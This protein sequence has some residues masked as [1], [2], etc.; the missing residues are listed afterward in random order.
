VKNEIFNIIKDRTYI[1]ITLYQLENRMEEYNLS[2]I[3]QERIKALYSNLLE[4]YSK[5]I[6]FDYS[7]KFFYEDGYGKDYHILNLKEAE[8]KEYNDDF[9]LANLLV[10]YEQKILYQD[11]KR[12]L[13]DYNLDNPLLLFVGHTVSASGTLTNDDKASISDVE[14]VIQFINKF[15]NSRSDIIRSI[16]NI[17]YKRS[18]KDREGQDVFANRF[19]YIK[20]KGLSPVDIYHDLL[21]T[22]FNATSVFSPVL[23]LYEIKNVEGEI[24]LKI[25]GEDYFGLI[26][27]GDISRLSKRM[28]TTGDY[29]I[30]E[31]HF[32]D[33]FFNNINNHNSA[34]NFLIGSRK[35]IEGWNSYRVSSIGLL[36][37]GRSEGSQIIQ[38]FG[39]GVRLRGLNNSLKRSA[40]FKDIEHPEYIE[41]LET[42]NIF[43]IKADYMEKFREYLEKE[44][45]D[46][47]GYEEIILSIKSNDEFLQ[48]DLL[49]IKLME[50]YS[51]QEDKFIPL[52]IDNNIDVTLD[53][54]PK[55]ERLSSSEQNDQE[56][57]ANKQR[58][59]IDDLEEDV[60]DYLNW[61]NLY[62]ELINYK[63][64]QGFNNI[65]IKK[66]I[67]REIISKK[68]Y[69]LYCNDNDITVNLFQDLADIEDI[70]S[71]ILKK[72]VSQ[73]YQER[74]LAYENSYLHFTPLTREDGNFADYAV[75]VEKKNQK[76]IKEIRDLISRKDEIYS[77]QLEEIE[78]IPNVY[79]DRHLFQPLLVQGGKIKST[80]VG[81]NKDEKFFVENLKEFFLNKQDS[82]FLKG[83]EI[84]ILRN[85]SRGKGV[86]FYVGVNFYPDFILW[87]KEENKQFI[88]FID[89]KGI[90]MLHYLQNPKIQLHR[91]LKDIEKELMYTV[92][93]EVILNSFI[94]SNTE[95]KII[96]KQW[97]KDKEE[98][99]ANNVLFA[100]DKDMIAMLFREIRNQEVLQ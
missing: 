98:L 11:K 73:F 43:G 26:N 42:L 85:L 17:I 14:F 76:L 13:E 99:E 71:K 72:Y 52:E 28:E 81:L 83:Q 24:G 96:R 74:K 9:L 44:G 15:L 95:S 18:F 31:D 23:E 50:G 12:I 10:F 40:G 35:F 56:G 4:E 66:D 94:I 90:L 60:L 55:L 92:D 64:Q 48:K 75:R 36:N 1:N 22:V 32:S 63:K 84:F 100:E 41:L 39:R 30:R 82:S 45:I 25:K 53:L 33:S 89:P 20:E 19:I 70:V 65:I 62:L 80:P 79:F 27:I 67:L 97:G 37:I 51:F 87:I 93:Y 5:A 34:I 7:Y 77:E 91:M 88:N 59:Y 8:I 78:S 68:L 2:E 61:N 58:Y 57:V 47:G 29:I 38:L 69:T 16:E 6:I 86:G 21:V 49:T 54:R 3:Q 46:T